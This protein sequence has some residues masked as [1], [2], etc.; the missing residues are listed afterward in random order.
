M[1]SVLGS[2]ES[3]SHDK[4]DIKPSEIKNPDVCQEKYVPHSIRNKSMYMYVMK[5]PIGHSQTASIVI[6]NKCFALIVTVS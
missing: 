3:S 1:L 2:R 4:A 6:C 5:L